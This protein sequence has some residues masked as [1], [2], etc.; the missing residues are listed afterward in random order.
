M[1]KKN[2]HDVVIVGAG[3]AGS[4]AAIILAQKGYDVLLLD[5]HSFP[6]DKICGDA[7]PAGT[8][9]RLWHYG[10]KDKIDQAVERG[11]FY[12]VDSLL[13]VS[14]R[15]YD[16]EADLVDGHEGAKSYVAPRMH[17]DA[18]MQQAAVDSGAK[19][20]Q[21]QA[22]APIME[23]GKVVGVEAQVNG[24]TQ[25]F[26]S[27]VL[28]GADG[29]TSVIAR[30][31]RPKEEQHEDKHRAIAIRAYIDDIEETPHEV[32]FYLYKEILPGYA[33]I[34]PT[35]N[36]SANIGLGMRL[37]H[38]R[39]HNKNLKKML[40]EFIDMPAVKKRLLNGGQLHDVATWQL[41]FGSQADMEYSFDGALLVGDAAGFINP[42]TGGGIYNSTLSAELA[43]QVI[44]KA[45]QSGDYSRQTL[46]EYDQLCHDAMWE[47]M[48]TSHR[49]QR[50]F[51]NFPWLVDIL[52]RFGKQ[53][54]SLTQI[55]LNKL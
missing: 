46:Q 47:N 27:K 2:E 41:N 7:V 15:G 30:N 48:K 13:L 28:V 34:F 37:D 6:R 38:F 17:F 54:D 29:V 36:Y 42:I 31:L 39:K 16:I 44:E 10:L 23:N 24:S 14:P 50:A 8:I 49:F 5:R 11:E 12:R 21:A 33:W 1:T 3:P 55:F 43:A 26:Y 53:S 45:L 9:E 32:E 18:L 40:Q 20:C 19:F 35:G 51:M 25:E 52:I 22:K 4:M